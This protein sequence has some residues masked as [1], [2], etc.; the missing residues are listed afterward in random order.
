MDIPE[1]LRKLC[2]EHFVG[3]GHRHSREGW[4]Q[5]DCPFC[6]KGSSKFHLGFNLRSRYFHCWHCG[7]H[8]ASEVFQELGAPR[9]LSAEVYKAWKEDPL[10][11]EPFRAKHRGVLKPP[12]GVGEMQKVH[13][14]YLRGRGF[15]PDD[16]A[17]VWALGG[18]GL[19][20]RNLAWRIYIPISEFGKQVSWTSRSIGDRQPRYLSAS[21]KEEA[22]PHKE[23][24]YGLDF[25]VNSV[26]VVEGPADAWRV[27]PGA[28]AVFGVSFSVSQV[29]RLARI[30]FRTICFDNSKDAQDRAD[31]LAQD[32]SAFPGRTQRVA[33][34]ADDPGSAGEREI[35]LL[36]KAAGLSR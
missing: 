23:V 1:L 22:V 11:P 25:C 6:G 28:G 31:Q 4:V 36:R 21:L 14:R 9:A 8:R 24:V 3:S 15:D 30:P 34:D 19:A 20:A 5:L 7:P 10:A 18:I 32:L 16:L 26:V 12:P 35:R 27:G 2:V 17:R 29:R 13:R 33:L